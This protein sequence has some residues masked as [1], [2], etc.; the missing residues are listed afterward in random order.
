MKEND[1]K[2]T[3]KR[4]GRALAA[5]VLL[6]Y[7]FAAGGAPAGE[8]AFRVNV[9]TRALPALGSAMREEN[10]YRGNATAVTV[11]AQVFEQA[12]SRCH[13]LA[14]SG[15]IGPDLRML[16]VSCR[17]IVDEVRR[18]ACLRDQD[19]YFLKTVRDGKIIVGVTHMP[20]WRDFMSQEAIWA[21]RS[22]IESHKR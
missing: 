21:I 19:H 2:A 14:T 3:A 5:A 9:D 4:A 11:G 17:K 12:C 16:D 7:G 8:Q 20:G 15:G 22:Y 10:P 6:L 18:A 1:K 13:V